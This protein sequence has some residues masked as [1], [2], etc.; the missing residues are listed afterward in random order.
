MFRD[1]GKGI[2]TS[3][4]TE[5]IYGDQ[6]LPKKFKM[7]VTTDP[8]KGGEVEG[9]NITVGG[10]LGRTHKKEATFARAADHLGYVPKDKLME[11]LK[12]I[13][14][15]YRDYGNREVRANARLKYLVHKLGIDKYRD[16]VHAY[17]PEAW[18]EPWRELPPWEYTDWM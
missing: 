13:L 12:A 7:A 10:G 18:I 17:L 5:P 14:A 8:K 1:T 15:T 9:F 6:Y 11:T 4:P 16:L 2:I 3:D